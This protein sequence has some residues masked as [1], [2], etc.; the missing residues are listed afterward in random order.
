MTVPCGVSEVPIE[1]WEPKETWV[2]VVVKAGWAPCYR[3]L[4]GDTTGQG[5]VGVVSVRLVLL[6][7][8][9]AVEAGWTVVRSGCLG[10]AEVWHTPTRVARCESSRRTLMHRER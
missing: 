4:R 9:C 10:Q 6:C 3:Y 7:D 8:D 5:A 2:Q 1:A